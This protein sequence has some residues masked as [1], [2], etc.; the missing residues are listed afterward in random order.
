MA[1]GTGSQLLF[2]EGQD[3]MIVWRARVITENRVGF[4]SS[5]APDFVTVMFLGVVNRCDLLRDSGLLSGWFT[6]TSRST[7]SIN[8]K[9]I[10]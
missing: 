5:A 3:L 4:S 2:I 7:T 10:Q 6:S 1:F 9:V 8:H